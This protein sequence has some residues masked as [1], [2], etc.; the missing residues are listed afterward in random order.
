MRPIIKSTS[1]PF[2]DNA[3]AKRICASGTPAIAQRGVTTQTFTA[4]TFHQTKN[5]IHQKP[6][7]PYVKKENY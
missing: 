4:H 6:I 3:R 7:Y 5:G 2:F 1:H